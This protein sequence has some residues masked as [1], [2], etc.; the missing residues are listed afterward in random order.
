MDINRNNYEAFLLD[1][2]EGRLSVSEERELK[3]FLKSH[4]EHVVDL[5]DIELLSL[6]KEHLSFPDRDQLKKQL[7]SIE[8]PLSTH[9]FDL[10]SIAR[11]EGDLSQQQVDAHRSAIHSDDGLLQEWTRWQMTR[12]VPERIQFPGKKSLKRRKTFRARM[13][14]MGVFSAAAALTLLLLL[15]KMNPADP[16]EENSRISA[17]VAPS[18]EEM[19]VDDQEVISAMPEQEDEAI[20]EQEARAM[21][22]QEATDMIPEEPLPAAEQVASLTDLELL[23]GQAVPD[24]LSEQVILEPRPLRIAGQLTSSPDLIGMNDQDRIEPL[25]YDQVSPN[26]TS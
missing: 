19:P 14:I 9:N 13:V 26:L 7:P 17:V 20:P 25:K 6:E 22:E 21:P 11:L 12:L 23:E 4:P 3:E 1:L 5:P 18:V 16:A 8:T 15:F 10:F 24:Q 2:L